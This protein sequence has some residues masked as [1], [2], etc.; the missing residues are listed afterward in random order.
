M[1][2]GISKNV[3]QANNI[4]I[5]RIKLKKDKDQWKKIYF[6]KGKVCTRNRC[7]DYKHY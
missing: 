5:F 4:Q 1:W 6:S 7:T 2:N 3:K